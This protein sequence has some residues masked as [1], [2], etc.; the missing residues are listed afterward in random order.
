MHQV[1][2]YTFFGAHHNSVYSFGLKV[3]RFYNIEEDTTTRIVQ[4]S[5]SNWLDTFNFNKNV[6]EYIWALCPLGAGVKVDS[7]KYE[8]FNGI[9][10]RTQYYNHGLLTVNRT[11]E[12]IGAVHSFADAAFGEWGIPLVTCKCYS[13]G[14]QVL[15]RNQKYFPQDSCY[16]K[17]RESKW[18]N[19]LNTLGSN[20]MDIVYSNNVLRVNG[21]KGISHLHLI[22]VQGQVVFKKSFDQLSLHESFSDLSKGIYILS[23]HSVKG[24]ENRKII[25]Q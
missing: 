12:G 13:K 17:P 21:N 8:L 3:D 9:T 14:G 1:E 7:V 23:V 25:I 5:N 2:Y 20:R 6:G 10:R 22:S 18:P 16:K 4:I 15:Y 24:V 11:I 19:R